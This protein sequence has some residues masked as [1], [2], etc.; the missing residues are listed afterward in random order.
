MKCTLL[1]YS[2]VK[3]H[4]DF[5]VRAESYCFN[6]EDTDMDLANHIGRENNKNVLLTPGPWVIELKKQSSVVSYPNRNPTLF[7]KF[8]AT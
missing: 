2:L 5:R 1:Q 3:S 4:V 7:G 6:L 8:R